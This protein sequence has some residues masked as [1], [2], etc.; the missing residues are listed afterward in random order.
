MLI[1]QLSFIGIVATV[2][3]TLYMKRRTRKVVKYAFEEGESVVPYTR[4]VSI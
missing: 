2:L 1:I 4:L 3:G